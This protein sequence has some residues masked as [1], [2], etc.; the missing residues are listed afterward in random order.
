[1]SQRR[2]VLLTGAAGV[3]GSALRPQL[4]RHRVV[5]LVHRSPVAGEYVHGDLCQPRLGLDEHTYR[6]L[7]STVDTVVHCAAETDFAAGAQ[8]VQRA[9]VAGTQHIL[10]FAAAA[11]ARLVHVSTA[12]VARSELTRSAKG[13]ALRDAVARPEDYLDSKRA[14][15]AALRSCGVPVVIVRP[16]VVIG[17]SATGEMSRFQGIHT[18]ASALLRNRLPLAPFDPAARIDVIPQD[19]LAAGIAALVESGTASGEY[20]LTAGPQ[21]LTAG[22]MVELCVRTAGEL[23]LEL[24]A[25]RLVKPAMVDRLIRPVFIDPLPAPARRKFDDLLAMAALFAGTEPFPTSL[26]APLPVDLPSASYFESAFRASL[27]YLARTKGFAPPAPPAPAPL[28]VV[29]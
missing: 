21:A 18:I 2:F 13:A 11:G 16:S 6:T 7:L 12:F 15:E 10:S 8:A 14:A 23:G 27:T 26:G 3:V 19:L 9:N 5:S 1:M 17:D 28:A 25:P 29:A 20:W 4:A 24:T 22:R